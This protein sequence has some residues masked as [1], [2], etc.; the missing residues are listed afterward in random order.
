[1][2]SDKLQFYK[3][4]GKHVTWQATYSDGA[5][6]NQ[7]NVDGSKNIYNNLKRDGL[8]NFSLIDDDGNRVISVDLEPGKVFFW[9]MR[10]AL[11]PSAQKRE[12]VHLVGWRKSNGTQQINVLFSDGKAKTFKRWQQSQWLYEPNWRLQEEV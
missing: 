5:I 4:I 9:R 10:V 1:M 12:R 8:A 7:Y 11:H 6:V 2:P 3:E